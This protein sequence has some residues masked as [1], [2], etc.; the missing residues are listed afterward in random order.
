M[1]RLRP[2]LDDVTYAEL[3]AQA[4]AR[5]PALAPQWTDHNPGDPGIMLLELFAWLAEMLVYQADQLPD[6]RTDA[7]LTLLNG[8]NWTRTVDL[9]TA[10]ADTLRALRSPWRAVTA[11][12]V[13]HLLT[14]V[15]P[16]NTGERELQRAHCVPERD[17]TAAP[18]GDEPAPGHLSVVVVPAADAPGLPAASPELCAAVLAWLE[19]RRLLGVRHHV[20]PAPYVPVTVTARLVLQ[21]DYAPASVASSGVLTDEAIE[22]EAGKLAAAA[23]AKHLHPLIGGADGTGWPFGRNMYTSELVAVLDGLHGVD[24]VEELRFLDPPSERQISADGRIVGVRLAPHELVEVTVVDDR[25][26]PGRLAVTLPRRAG[27]AR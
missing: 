4:R 27:G 12:D 22:L 15:W 10:V 17:L 5:I 18:G 26:R 23:V 2:V 21:E 9:D 1:T 16:E 7:F 25:R 20:L 3:V 6:D 14:R 8:P 24:F 11:D 19:P 13:V